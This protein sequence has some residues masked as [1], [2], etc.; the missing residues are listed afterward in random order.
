M[1]DLNMEH[2]KTVANAVEPQFWTVDDDVSA[3][4]IIIEQDG[5]RLQMICEVSKELDNS[6]TDVAEYIA[7]FDPIT[8]LDLLNHVDS[9]KNDVNRLE[10]KKTTI[11]DLAGAN[12]RWKLEKIATL[13]ARAE[14]AER[15]LEELRKT[16]R[17]RDEAKVPPTVDSHKVVLHHEVG[18]I[19]WVKSLIQ[20]RI[21][22]SS[23]KIMATAD[24]KIADAKTMKEQKGWWQRG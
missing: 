19:V 4:V 6:G 20:K 16:E 18:R 1:S 12:H 9:L 8:V 5:S 15:E 3:G 21:F 13:T 22:E 24:K 11:S 2:L 23:Q 14:T 17:I 10:R 7:T